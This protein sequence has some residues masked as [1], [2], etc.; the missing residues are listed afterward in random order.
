[1]KQNVTNVSAAFSQEFSVFQEREEV[2][3]RIFND[4]TQ[5][6]G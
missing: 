5:F 3:M 2:G 1:M 6:K 4:A